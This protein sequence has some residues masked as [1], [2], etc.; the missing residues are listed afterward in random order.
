[1]KKNA[2][3]GMMTQMS[4]TNHNWANDPQIPS[5]IGILRVGGIAKPQMSLFNN[6][7]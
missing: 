3:D 1:M 2:I 5:S 4:S 6:D 7:S